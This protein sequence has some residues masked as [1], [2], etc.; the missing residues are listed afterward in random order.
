MA[1]NVESGNFGRCVRS[2]FDVRFDARTSDSG[3]YLF[4]KMISGAYLG[5][6]GL[7]VLQ[8]A[9]QEGFFSAAAAD[10]LLQWQSLH[11]KDFDEFVS[12]P[13]VKDT[14]FDAVP[15]TD[16]DRRAV[17]ALCTPVFERAALL[18]AVNISAAVV[19]TGGGRDPLYPTCVT[20]DGSTYYRTRSTCLKS[21]IEGHLRAILGARGLHYELLQIDDAP[22]VGAAVAGLMQDGV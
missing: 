6:V 22:I 21:V 5:G 7:E 17:M 1:I 14:V 15:L 3:S 10:V 13:F 2:E 4:E 8:Q 18:A 11:N 19:K 12:N 9:A 16:D 20:I